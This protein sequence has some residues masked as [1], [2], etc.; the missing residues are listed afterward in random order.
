MINLE[1]IPKKIQKRLFEKMRA[2]G[3]QSTSTTGQSI[4]TDAL[5]HEKMESRTTFIRMTSGQTNAVT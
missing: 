4:D 5:T 2:L 3:R 1:P